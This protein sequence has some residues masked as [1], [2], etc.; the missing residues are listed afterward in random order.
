MYIVHQDIEEIVM[1]WKYL[2]RVTV[3]STL[4]FFVYKWVS[5]SWVVMPPTPPSI[6]VPLAEA[7]KTNRFVF[8]SDSRWSGGPPYKISYD[9]TL[10]TIPEN[11]LCEAVNDWNLFAQFNC[12]WATPDADFAYTRAIVTFPLPEYD[13]VRG[14]RFERE[15]LTLHPIIDSHYDDFNDLLAFV[16]ILTIIIWGFVAWPY[17]LL[18]QK[19]I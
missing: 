15:S 5:E 18:Q 13:H 16:L 1:N 7:N 4:L 8:P 19:L 10:E 6:V 17:H 11:S 9:Y 2:L 3:V 14:W 12:S